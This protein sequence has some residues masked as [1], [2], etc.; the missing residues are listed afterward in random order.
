M[1]GLHALTCGRGGWIIARHNSVRDKLA[2]I[3]KAHSPHPVH[4]E[5]HTDNCA[6]DRHPDIRFTDGKGE[7]VWLDV[8]IVTPT[9]HTVRTSGTRAERAGALAASTELHKRAKYPTL[10]LVPFVLETYGH[11]GDSALAVVRALCPHQEAAERSAWIK[12]QWRSL[13][14]TAARGT[15]QCLAKGSCLQP[16]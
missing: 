6:D 4:I 16:P 2:D 12:Q 15:V 1:K 10:K 7:D 9:V 13:Q 3:I 8:S 14:T 5:P 11:P